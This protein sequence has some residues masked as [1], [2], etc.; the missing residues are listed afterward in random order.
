MANTHLILEA[1]D[2]NRAV[3]EEIV[4]S[5]RYWFD[6]EAKEKFS[7]QS[8]STCPNGSRFSS[9]TFSEYGLNTTE[10]QTTYITP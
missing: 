7:N 3:E 4:P 8:K 10:T 5:A 1:V 9:P 2:A 6:S